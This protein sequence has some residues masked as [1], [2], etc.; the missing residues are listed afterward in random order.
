MEEEVPS[1]VKTSH[2]LILGGLLLALVCLFEIH[3]DVLV[4]NYNTSTKSFRDAMSIF[5]SS[6]AEED[7]QLYRRTKYGYLHPTPPYE[8]VIRTSHTCNI[9]SIK[10]NET[11]LH[12]PVATPHLILIGAQKSGTSSFQSMI[13]KRINVITPLSVNKFEPH[14]FDFRERMYSRS[15]MIIQQW[16]IK[17]KY[18]KRGSNILNTLI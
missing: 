15:I 18:A 10:N 5:K 8:P 14:F 1:T 12:L 3:Y 7:H 16:N 4:E 17:V 6:T 11:I 2:K 9:T 13:D